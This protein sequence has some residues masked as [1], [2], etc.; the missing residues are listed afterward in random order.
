MSDIQSHPVVLCV[1]DW[2]LPR[3]ERFLRAGEQA[4]EDTIGALAGDRSARLRCLREQ[5]C[6]CA[7]SLAGAESHLIAEKQ[8]ALLK[9]L[10]K[11]A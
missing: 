5:V 9:S 2:R 8:L 1:A 4:S 11:G 3:S 10:K 7:D 6:C